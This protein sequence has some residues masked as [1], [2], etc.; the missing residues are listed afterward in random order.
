[1]EG[2]CIYVES[3]SGTAD[4]NKRLDFAEWRVLVKRLLPDSLPVRREECFSVLRTLF[5]ENL[6][7]GV[8]SALSS[9]AFMGL[10]HEAREL[11]VDF[12][13]EKHDSKKISSLLQ[14][15]LLSNEISSL[16]ALNVNEPSVVDGSDSE[17]ECRVVVDDDNL[18]DWNWT[19]SD[20]VR[21]PE[22][23]DIGLRAIA[24]QVQG[25]IG[26]YASVEKG[27]VIPSLAEPF[28]SAL[29]AEKTTLP[30]PTSKIS[31]AEIALVERTAKLGTVAMDVLRYFSDNPGD[32]AAHAEL[33]L[34]YPL[35]DINKLLLGSLSNYVKKTGSGGWEC[36]SWVSGLLLI[37]D[38]AL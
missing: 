8:V 26:S 13:C 14:A 11:L 35:A 18:Q 5:G 3:E 31:P 4:D 19:A 23:D 10:E 2:C 37:L 22:I 32:R 6:P 36:Y 27:A 12:L 17:F 20:E 38:D 29:W 16:V 15:R 34:G 7:N 1:M 28:D 25:A 24:S 30:T 21:T 33:V 9:L